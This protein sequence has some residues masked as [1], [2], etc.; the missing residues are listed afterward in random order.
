MLRSSDNTAAWV[1]TT[2]LGFLDVFHPGTKYYA[3][4]NVDRF[5]VVDKTEAV[6]RNEISV[7]DAFEVARRMTLCGYP[8]IAEVV[9]RLLRVD[10]FDQYR[11][12]HN[13]ELVVAAGM[14]Y[15]P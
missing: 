8:H 4:L 12:D 9:K 3:L 13:L 5:G 15:A 2:D 7:D 6:V 14:A 10:Q 11:G 1:G